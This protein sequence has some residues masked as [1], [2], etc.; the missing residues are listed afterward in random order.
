[1]L[2]SLFCL[3]FLLLNTVVAQATVLPRDPGIARLSPVQWAATHVGQMEVGGLPVIVS[4]EQNESL[5]RVPDIM[6]DRLQT[7]VPI[8]NIQ[9]KE[10]RVSLV[11]QENSSFRANYA[12]VADTVFVDGAPR[13]AYSSAQAEK[14]FQFVVVTQQDGTLA[15]SFT[16]RLPE[17]QIESG[18]AQLEPLPQIFRK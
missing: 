4:L 14:E 16:R 7:L 9:K 13:L 11:L 15:L 12:L 2:R 10:L 3:A 8:A 5:S 1:M 17:G 6:A 18:S